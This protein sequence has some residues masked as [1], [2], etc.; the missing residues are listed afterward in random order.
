MATVA[1]LERLSALT[2]RLIP[3]SQFQ[4]GAL[5]RADDWNLLIAAV[6]ELA[7]ALILDTESGIVTEHEHPDEVD[8]GWLTP[9]LRELIEQGGLSD[10]VANRRLITLERD[11]QKNSKQIDTLLLTIG[12]FRSTVDDV[13]VNDIGRDGDIT[14]LRRRFEA[15]SNSQ[16]EV[17]DLRKSLNNIKDNI[18]KALEMGELITVDGEIADIKDLSERI[19]G[20]ETLRDSLTGPDGN[21]LD[22]SSLEIRLAELQTKFVNQDQLDEAL[23]QVRVRPPQDLVDTLRADLQGFVALEL[24]DSLDAQQIQYDER[25]VNTGELTDQL[26]TRDKTLVAQTDASINALSERISNDL[27]ANTTL[28]SRLQTLSS[29]LS[30]SLQV[31]INTQLDGRLEGLQ[32]DFDARYISSQQLNTRL[33]GLSSELQESITKSVRTDITGAV[34]TELQQ[35]GKELFVSQEQFSSEM[36]AINK[37]V[38]DIRQVNLTDIRTAVAVIEDTNVSNDTFDARLK[39]QQEQID[40]SIQQRIDEQIDEQ[41]KALVNASLGDM[42]AKLDKL[43]SLENRIN[44]NINNQLDG[45]RQDFSKISRQAIATELQGIQNNLRTVQDQVNSINT[46]ISADVDLA[47]SSVMA[48][49]KQE[50]Q[51]DFKLVQQNI[52]RMDKQLTQIRGDNSTV[53]NP[54]DRS[55]IRGLDRTNASLAVTSDFTEI[56]GIGA[57][58]AK[59]LTDNGIRHFSELAK[60]SSNELASILRTRSDTVDRLQLQRKAARKLQR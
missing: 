13:K 59:R 2:Q 22:A 23:E 5:I 56:E 1:E 58:F 44:T 21:V 45:L 53:G 18:D 26:N 55:R 8:I 16:D 43:D 60:L 14:I 20:L 32:T 28:D 10:P 12:K 30:N 29:T 7:R 4:R 11:S 54:N 27:V 38:D 34:Q 25:Y 42:N 9:R 3:I 48:E 17:L 41:V 33:A 15:Q 6:I 35:L 31:D 52:T 37:R 24:T 47:V 51:A 39:T 36:G 19:I 46:R 57:V 49:F 40:A 50:V